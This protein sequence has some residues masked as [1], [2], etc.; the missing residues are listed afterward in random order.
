MDCPTCGK[1][2]STEQGMRQHHTKVHG[3]TL[4]NRTCADCGTEFYDAKSQRTYCEDCYSQAGEKNG[5]YSG[6]KETTEC[7]ECGD[8]FA[9]YPSNKDGV[10]CSAC[11]DEADGVVPTEASAVTDIEVPCE[12]C[13]ATLERHPSRIESASYGEFCDLDCYGEWLSDHVVGSSHHQWEGGTIP[14]GSSW[15][16]VRR[17]AWERDGYECQCCGASTEEIGRRPD[18]H[19]IVPVRAFDNPAD[20]HR[21]ENVVC[22]CR[23]C[24]R[25]VEDGDLSAPSVES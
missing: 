23:S 13:G 3:D 24:H 15:W 12:N 14:Y 19:H 5:N 21:L 25:R 7:N 8:A 10:Y 9:Y 20:A 11:V 1:S 4:P 22:L 2:L 6:A 17:A 16:Q 18:V